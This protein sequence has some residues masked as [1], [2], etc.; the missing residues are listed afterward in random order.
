LK[1]AV[2]AYSAAVA[3]LVVELAVEE[4]SSLMEEVAFPSSLVED[5]KDQWAKELLEVHQQIADEVGQ[6]AT[7]DFALLIIVLPLN[8]GVRL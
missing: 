1:E 7:T 8:R 4:D 2:E 5:L 6:L 3:F